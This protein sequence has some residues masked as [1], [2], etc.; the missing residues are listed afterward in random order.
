MSFRAWNFE[1]KKFE[2]FK[3]NN[4]TCVLTSTL[5]KQN[6]FRIITNKFIKTIINNVSKYF[7]GICGAG[8]CIFVFLTVKN[9]EWKKM[10]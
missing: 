9:S 5:K 4:Y 3:E 7:M 1:F 10:Q 6:Y 8:F 2:T